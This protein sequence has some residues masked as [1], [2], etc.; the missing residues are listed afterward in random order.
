MPTLTFYGGV[1]EI[2][3]NK[4]L[5]EDNDTR[6]FLDFGQ[7]FTH[8]ED[9][10]VEWLQPRGI[11]G[12]GDYFEFCLLPKL[13]GVY[14]EAMLEDTD[15]EYTEPV[16]DAIFL[17][18]AHFDHMDHIRFV[19]EAIPIYCGEAT[20]KFIESMEE[21]SPQANYGSHPYRTFRTGDG[22]K[23]GSI[24]VEPIH[25][26]HSI[27][28]A[29][30][31]IIETSKGNIVYTGDL[32]LHGPMSDMTKEF[33]QKAKECKPIAM[34]SEGTR[35]APE[36]KRDNYS[37]GKVLET[38]NRIV[39]DTNKLVVVTHYGRDIDRFMTFYHVANENKRKFIIPPK[40][41]Y[42]LDKLKDDPKLSVPD[43]KNDENI[44][45]YYRRKK[46]GNFSEK[47]YYKWEREFMDK[48]VTHEYIH[49]NQGKVLL[50]LN[51]YQ[52][53]ELIDIRPDPNSHFIH[54]MSEPFSEEDIEDEVTHN[55]LNHF[56]FEFH[57]IHA[58]G[59][60]SKEELIEMITEINPDSLY[61]IHTEYPQMFKE[62]FGG[63]VIS[64]KIQ[65]RYKIGEKKGSY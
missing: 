34:V 36:E 60:A 27:P 28:G 42:L 12:L 21:T 14:S 56:K 51:F 58:S 64:P 9:Y 32:R 54:S 18:H 10:F 29:Y 49:D 30:G 37:E 43:I 22:I 48:L 17:S 63:K 8:G 45:V 46:S 65:K 25:V 16:I 19:D 52:F 23:L 24:T 33:I 5:L 50:Y 3:G 38:S 15:L 4:I 44:F 57:Q 55:W 53:A 1:A 39:S 11:N 2:G 20:T 40:T 47:D 13:K 6:I 26:D 61:P 41:A 31:F 7:S 59:H 62:F 35:M